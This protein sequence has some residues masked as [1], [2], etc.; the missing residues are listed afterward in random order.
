MGYGGEVALGPLDLENLSVA[1][2][3]T[4]EI[5]HESAGVAKVPKRIRQFLLAAGHSVVSHRSFPG[6]VGL[7]QV[8][9]MEKDPSTVLVVLSHERV[10]ELG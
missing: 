4:R 2:F 8:T 10:L 9:T 1:L 5:I 3:R 7:D 6:C